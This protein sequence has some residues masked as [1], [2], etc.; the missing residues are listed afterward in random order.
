MLY[1]YPADVIKFLIYEVFFSNGN[2]APTPL[3]GAA[4]GAFSTSIAQ[5]ITTPLDVVRNRIMT[6]TT[7]KQQELSYFQT[8]SKIAREEGVQGLF[9]GA[10]PRIGKAFLSGAI[11]FAAYEET[12]VAV[13]SFLKR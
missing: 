7:D 13:N 12:K 6:G 3:E 8:L 10:T 5:F 4:Y 9:S 1:S 11:Q 2:I